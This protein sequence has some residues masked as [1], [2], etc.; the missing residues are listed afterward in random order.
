MTVPATRAAAYRTGP[1][2]HAD[3]LIGGMTCASC[4]ARVER[5]LNRLDGVSATVNLA[6]ATA[7]VDFDPA[8]TTTDDLVAAVERTGYTAALPTP[9][10]ADR[11]EDDDVDQGR[12]RL[13]R[14]LISAPLTL[15]V[16]ATAMLP[17]PGLSPSMAAWAGVIL[18][19]PVVLYGG[20]PFH[21]AAALNARHATATMDTLVSLGT[22]AAYLWSL[23]QLLPGGHGH[24]YSEVAAT[25]TTFLLLGRYAEARARH[26]AGSALRALLE[27]GAKHVTVLD[28]DGTERLVAADSLRVGDRFVVR[29]GEKVATDGVVV[30]G[31][32]AVDE[33]MLTGESVPVD[34]GPGEPVTGA[35][36]NRSG[37][38]VV[39]ARRIGADTAL[40]QIA[41][42]VAQAQSGKAPV[43]RL[44]DRIS[45]VFVPAVV[46]LS[47][48]TLGG[49]LLAGHP[50]ETGFGAAIA[51][52]I[53][54]CPCALGLATPTALLVGS[55][56]GAQLGIV[57]RGP[58]VLEST[59][60]IDTVVLDKTG[61]VTTGTM[62]VVDVASVDE[63]AVR[64]AA[65]AEAGS[66]HPVGRAITAYV[67][68]SAL[69]GLEVGCFTNR[70]GL[71][72]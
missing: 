2:Q 27:A 51:V 6:T 9:S 7:S 14:L 71:G 67:G 70:E 31:S 68:A 5:R 60:R 45:G 3:L 32:S 17:L 10:T 16:L 57:I 41:R 42:L 55:G 63:R 64:L 54:A 50:F 36:V 33:S 58:Q 44:A 28:D 20:W 40:A 15:L 65:A 61:T 37:R 39:E 72:V 34:K 69:A 29:P 49:W 47:L 19:T 1:R 4:V 52:L 43:Q 22:V 53:I 30:A 62:R 48:L 66:E 25:V 11:A 21:R 59:R 56:R 12:D 24:T 38:L 35:T 23:A 26:R 13:R 8:A 46:G 18:T